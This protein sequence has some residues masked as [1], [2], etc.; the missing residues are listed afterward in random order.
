MFGLAKTQSTLL[1]HLFNKY[2]PSATYVSDT[3]LGSGNSTTQT[4]K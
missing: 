4:Y 2:S 3:I 1:I